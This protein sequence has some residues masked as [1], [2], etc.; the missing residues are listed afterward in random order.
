[1]PRQLKDFITDFFSQSIKI[2]GI[3]TVFLMIDWRVFVV[4][5]I[6][7]I[8]DLF[9]QRYIY[10]LHEAQFLHFEYKNDYQVRAISGTFE[11]HLPQLVSSGGFNSQLTHLKKV[12]AHRLLLKKKYQ[13]K[14]FFHNILGFI[15]GHISEIFIK[16]I[17]GF[18]VFTSTTSLGTMTMTL[19]YIEKIESFLRFIAFLPRK[20]QEILDDL[21]QFDIFLEI[22]EEKENKNIS[23][24]KFTQISFQDV[25][26]SYPKFAE[27][28]LK[29]LKISER[30]MRRD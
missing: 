2:I 18:S 11:E 26:F 29:F 8:L 28:E 7:T 25:S 24:K 19:L 17:V 14:T 16:I 9:L 13:K 23:E 4:L 22:T 5:I 27:I 21:A 15:L 12:N 20:T 1:M 3:L 10:R 30:R 6:A